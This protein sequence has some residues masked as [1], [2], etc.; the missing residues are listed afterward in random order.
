MAISDVPPAPKAAFNLRLFV[1]QLHWISA[2]FSLFG[3]C[4]YAFTGFALNNEDLFTTKHEITRTV[5]PIPAAL[6]AKPLSEQNKALSPEAR[7]ELSTALGVDMRDAKVRVDQGKVSLSIPSPGVK[8]M[9]KI[10]QADGTLTLEQDK[11]GLIATLTDMHKG[12]NV[13][14]IWGFAIDAMAISVLIFALSGLYLL[15]QQASKRGI[16]W[17]LII[18]GTF[19]PIILAWLISR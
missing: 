15:V 14:P 13:R 9:V 11:R 19:I 17:P 2:A 4:F 8:T 18:G 7:H 16:T 1:R 10:N 12:K 5:R 6:L 3:L